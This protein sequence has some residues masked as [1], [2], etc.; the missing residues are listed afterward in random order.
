MQGL[1]GIICLLQVAC[2][3]PSLLSGIDYSKSD[4]W[5]VGAMIAEIL[6]GWNPFYRCANNPNPL[7]STSYKESDLPEVPGPP[8]LSALYKSL[9]TVKPSQVLVLILITAFYKLYFYNLIQTEKIVFFKLLLTRKNNQSSSIF[10]GY[11]KALIKG[12]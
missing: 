10:G 4:G 1:I 6:L 7:F 3:Q 2:A 12:L 9:L 11:S 5:A 8:I